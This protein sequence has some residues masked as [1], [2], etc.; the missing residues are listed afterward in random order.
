MQHALLSESELKVCL[1]LE[2]I[3]IIVALVP[4]YVFDY[5]DSRYVT[6]VQTKNL[7]KIMQITL[8]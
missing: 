1:P 7:G 8:V 4:F 2:N 5:Q 3:Q 6:P